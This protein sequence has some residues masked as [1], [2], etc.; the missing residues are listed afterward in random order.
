[1]VV[2][3]DDESLRMQLR[4]VTGP[5]DVCSLLRRCL[6]V[7]KLRNVGDCT[8]GDKVRAGMF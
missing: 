6:V 5:A 4:T 7:L 2:R 1:M 8:T 3:G